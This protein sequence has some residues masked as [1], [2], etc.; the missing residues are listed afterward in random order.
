[1]NFFLSGD[2]ILSYRSIKTQLNPDYKQ[3][4]QN[5]STL[6]VVISLETGV[7]SVKY[8]ADSRFVKILNRKQFQ[9]PRTVN[10]NQ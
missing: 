1:M 10:L 3:Q 7:S 4:V 2:Y 6:P 8:R 5:N 9:K